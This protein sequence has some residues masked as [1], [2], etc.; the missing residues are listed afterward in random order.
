MMTRPRR[1]RVFASLFVISCAAAVITYAST[2]AAPQLTITIN[3]DATTV[4]LE[5]GSCQ[6]FSLDT[7]TTTNN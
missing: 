4:T 7:F 1:F 6:A 2:Q 5:A 3:N